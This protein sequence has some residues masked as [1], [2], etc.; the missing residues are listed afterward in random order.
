MPNTKEQIANS[1]KKNFF[2]GFLSAALRISSK[3]MYKMFTGFSGTFKRECDAEEYLKREINP[4][5][6]VDLIDEWEEEV[7]IPDTCF[8]KEGSIEQRRSQVITKLTAHV[9]TAQDFVDLAAKLGVE[10]SVT[11]K[12]EKDG[13]PLELPYELGGSGD[14]FTIIVD[15]KGWTPSNGFPLKLPYKLGPEKYASVV[16]CLFDLLR[17]ANC[18]IEYK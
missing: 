10:V 8:K 18:K 6:T 16:Q 13:F 15:I 12:H 11:P 5:T 3:N 9:Q 2:T 14:F 4:A 17:P 1:L 7:G